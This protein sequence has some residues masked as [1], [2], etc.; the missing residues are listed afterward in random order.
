MFSAFH[1]S[2]SPL[3]FRSLIFK[4]GFSIFGFNCFFD[5]FR[6]SRFL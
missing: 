4:F 2:S 5:W 1:L 3:S 6:S